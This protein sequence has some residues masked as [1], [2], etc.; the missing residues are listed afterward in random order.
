MNQQNEESV[1][2]FEE[3][4]GVVEIEYVPSKEEVIAIV[5][6]PT[7]GELHDALMYIQ[8]M[9]ERASIPFMVLGNIAKQLIFT[10]LPS[11]DADKV[12]VGVM[13]NHYTQSGRSM[14]LSMIQKYEEVDNKVLLEY[15]GTPIQ[16][17][18]IQSEYE[19]FKN[20]DCKFYMMSE[21]RTPNPFIAYWNL[22][23]IVK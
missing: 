23:E 1:N 13:K 15:R 8:D 17:D 4:R 3:N 16:I 22:R 12:H 19:F 2:K 18:I 5:S 9:L 6:K 11:F 14:L 20:P 10:D 21:F 7:H